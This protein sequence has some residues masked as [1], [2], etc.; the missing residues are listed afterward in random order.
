MTPADPDMLAMA[1]SKTV[2]QLPWKPEVAWIAGDLVMNGKTGRAI[3]APR[4]GAA[5]SA[6]R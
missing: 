4:A 3:A 6:R 1:D 5:S 2:I